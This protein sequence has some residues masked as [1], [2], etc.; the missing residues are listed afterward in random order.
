MAR[1]TD[2]TSTYSGGGLGTG[3][4]P[5]SNRKQK[6]DNSNGTLFIPVS[7]NF[8]ENL[9]NQ[10][11]NGYVGSA[12]NVGSGE[13]SII[14]S[15]SNGFSGF[16]NLFSSKLN[17]NTAND[18]NIGSGSSSSGII[19][20]TNGSGNNY[21]TLSDIG[22]YQWNAATDYNDYARKDTL[23]WQEYMSNTAHQRE[24]ADLKAAGLNPILSAGGNGAASYS[25]VTS[26]YDNSELQAKVALQAAKINAASAVQIANINASATRYAANMNGVGNVLRTIGSLGS[27]WIRGH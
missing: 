7:G 25:G 5:Y 18:K 16:K 11:V 17:A 3:F 4:T 19:N 20:L 14:N 27:A 21:S 13:R 6:S 1:Y 9:V 26:S 15:L 8:T 22:D 2:D 24:V 10:M 12:L 23:A